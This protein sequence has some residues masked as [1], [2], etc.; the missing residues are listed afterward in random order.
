ML[1]LREH[2]LRHKDMGQ[3][4]LVEIITE[5]QAGVGFSA[6]QSFHLKREIAQRSSEQRVFTGTLHRETGERLPLRTEEVR[7]AV[8]AEKSLIQARHKNRGAGGFSQSAQV[9]AIEFDQ[10][11]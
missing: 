3:V 9:A 1:V 7:L 2:Q 8:G 11:A 10:T 6:Q 5:L 4:G